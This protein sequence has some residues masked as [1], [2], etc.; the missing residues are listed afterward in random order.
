MKRFIR[1]ISFIAAL[2]M[3]TA[4][5]PVS[6][7]ALKLQDY[8]YKFPNGRFGRDVEN[9]SEPDAA[10]YFDSTVK[11]SGN[12]S[13]K[14]VSEAGPNSNKEFRTIVGLA[15]MEKDKEYKISFMLKGANVNA[16]SFT[17]TNQSN[18]WQIGSLFGKNFDWTPVELDFTYPSATPSAQ[19]VFIVSKECDGIWIDDLKLYQ[20]ND[21]GSYSELSDAIENGD[22]EQTGTTP[23]IKESQGAED[24]NP[25]KFTALSDDDA[26]IVQKAEGITLDGDASDW[27]KYKAHPITDWIQLVESEQTLAADI[28][29]AYDDDAF[30]YMVQVEDET[31]KYVEASTYWKG[32]SLQAAID[33]NASNNF[34]VPVGTY[35]DDAK[36][37]IVFMSD[38]GGVEMDTEGDN[39][40]NGAAKRVGTT[41]TYEVRVPWTL[42]G[43]KRP[44]KIKFSL[45]VNDNDTGVRKGFL[46]VAEGVSSPKISTKFPYLYFGAK[47][48][49]ISSAKIK[50]SQIKLNEKFKCELSYSNVR[51]R[52]VD[53]EI[54]CGDEVRN[55]KIDPMT[56][57]INMIELDDFDDI[58]AY[59][60]IITIDDGEHVNDITVTGTVVPD[61]EFVKKFQKTVSSWVAELSFMRDECTEKGLPIPYEKADIRLLK[62]YAE[63]T[64]PF[65]LKHGQYA[66][67]AHF[68]DVL[69]QIYE[70]CRDSLKAILSGE[71]EAVDVPKYVTSDLKIRDGAYWG[72]VEKD[73][74]Q[75]ESPITFN[76]VCS[77]TAPEYYIDDFKEYGMNESEIGVY[78]Y[79]MIEWNGT[80]FVTVPEE[81]RLKRR[82]DEYSWERVIQQ[83]EDCDKNGISVSLIVN[84]MAW[85]HMEEYGYSDYKDSTNHTYNP[86]NV[87]HPMVAVVADA[88]Y[89]EVGKLCDKY[90]CIDNICILNEPTVKLAG[91]SYYDGQWADFLK[92]RYDGDIN[93]LNKVYGDDANYK[94][95]SEIKMPGTILYGVPVYHDYRMFCEDVYHQFV[96][97]ITSAARKYTDVPLCAKEMQRL[98]WYSGDYTLNMATTLEKNKDCYDL[99][100]CDA[101]YVPSS[102]GLGLDVKMMWYDYITSVMEA[103]VQNGEDH[104]G[105]DGQGGVENKYYDDVSYK[106]ST[107]QGMIHGGGGQSIWMYSDFDRN[108]QQGNGSEFEPQVNLLQLPKSLRDC[109]TNN[110]D[111][112]RLANEV[113]A[114]YTAPRNVGILWAN[115]SWGY[116]IKFTNGLYR[117]Y[118]NAIYNGQRVKFVT[119]YTLEQLD[120][121]KLLV[122]PG[123]TH[124]L[125][126]TL[127]AIKNYVDNGGKIVV[128]GK[129]SLRFDDFNQLNDRETVDYILSKATIIDS[130]V[131]SSGAAI[132][133]PEN[134]DE[135]MTKEY[136]NAGLMNVV[137]KDAET[138]EKI[139]GVEWISN[140]LNGKTVIN[141]FNYDRENKKTVEI[142]I[143]GEK[144][145]NFKDLKG[146]K[147]YGGTIT[148]EPQEPYLIEIGG[149]AEDE[150]DDIAHVGW[151][152][153]AISKL[154]RENV[155]N[156]VADRFFAPDENVTREQIA[157]MI[158]KVT[159][160]DV[161]N[162]DV[163]F[164]DVDDSEWYAPFVKTAYE[165]E[166][167]KGISAAEFGIGEAITRQDL[168]VMVYRAAKKIGKIAGNADLN[169]YFKD[170]GNVSDYAKEAVAAL[171]TNGIINGDEN[172]NFNPNDSCTRAEAAKIIY[173]TFLK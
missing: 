19:A 171:K 149:N 8:D 103:P 41:T 62:R 70:E 93:K 97:T 99:A 74:V 16:L 64:I 38:N 5:L 2:C 31:H 141:P 129:D 148:L 18:W 167:A 11:Y 101:F 81:G 71:K 92:E 72:T 1:L 69:P 25:E 146:G 172:G 161:K 126:G 120:K 56:K 104:I 106:A 88:V 27:D 53:V 78:A 147:T 4:L 3:T 151:A 76:G 85:P 144:V 84:A 45:I 63:T 86:F 52:A 131:L 89:K 139:E 36:N 59:K 48:G 44:D 87:N 7:S 160:T 12:Y 122:I 49:G 60:K 68:Y 157:K 6:V 128:I 83:L 40:V 65:E 154:C 117:A 28:K 79:M 173:N 133:L 105:S 24:E 50:E 94:D 82:A 168:T 21:N 124:I 123:T 58:G 57:Y 140:K 77:F 127:S 164:A 32:D 43:T 170:A 35:F 118:E 67:V 91:N 145:D 110:M 166:F 17:I 162:S 37:K 107:W 80:E 142:W 29:Y 15:K 23:I 135:I 98:R 10:A 113:N 51:D 96:E 90:E 102:N 134:Y 153:E 138:G 112:L 73:G 61:D 152:N 108:I 26:V 13:L 47:G 156:G 163:T 109:Y 159:K 95:F 14:L 30:Y 150:F 34:G 136:E 116:N 165:I 115:T 54:K 22:F 111:A 100:G 143:N 125:P 39:A 121:I 137:L 33:N 66:R 20:K 55:V 114:L 9:G 130:N 46:Q 158:V 119:E 132:E 169:A 155:I 75:Y 42:V